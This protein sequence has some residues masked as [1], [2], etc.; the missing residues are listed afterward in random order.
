MVLFLA[1]S[2]SLPPAPSNPI[3]GSCLVKTRIPVIPRQRPEHLLSPPTIISTSAQFVTC[4]PLP[5]PPTTIHTVL[6]R[7][8][9]GPLS[10]PELPYHQPALP[11]EQQLVCLSSYSRSFFSPLVNLQLVVSI[12]RLSASERQSSIRFRTQIY[13]PTNNSQRMLQSL[14]S[15]YAR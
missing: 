8:R 5:T 2:Y 14:Q 11:W 4:S 12:F 3:L 15:L 9:A 10:R 1:R 13:A 7:H 6:G